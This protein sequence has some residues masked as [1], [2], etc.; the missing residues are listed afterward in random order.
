MFPTVVVSILLYGFITW[1]LTKRMAKKADRNY[2]RMLRAILNK[3]R[4]QHPTKQQLHGHRTPIFKT[5]Q[6]KRK[7]HAEYCWWSKGEFI[8]DI[9]PWTYSQQELTYTGCRLEDLPGAM[10]DRDERQ[11]RAREICAKS[12]TLWWWNWRK[13]S[14]IHSFPKTISSM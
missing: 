9:L 7:R 4:K 10:D 1:T 14:W 12:A 3:S 8:S 11:E 2:T 5:I 13:N 6:I